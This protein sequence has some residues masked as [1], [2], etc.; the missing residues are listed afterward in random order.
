MRPYY[1]YHTIDGQ[2]LEERQSHWAP[3]EELVKKDGAEMALTFYHGGRRA[4]LK[5]NAPDRS[6]SPPKK[7]RAPVQQRHQLASLS[8]AEE[9]AIARKA[10][11]QLIPSRPPAA[12]EVSARD[13]LCDADIDSFVFEDGKTCSAVKE[14]ERHRLLE[15]HV[16][17]ARLARRHARQ[18]GAK[19]KAAGGGVTREGDT[20]QEAET[21]RILELLKSG[22]SGV[23]AKAPGCGGDTEM[24]CVVLVNGDTDMSCLASVAAP[25]HNG[26]SHQATGVSASSADCAPM[27]VDPMEDNMGAG[28]VSMAAP[29]VAPAAERG[30]SEQA[31][32]GSKPQEADAHQHRSEDCNTHK[33]KPGSM[34]VVRIGD[35]TSGILVAIHPCGRV[36]DFCVLPRPEST[37][38]VAWMLAK[39]RR[40]LLDMGI[41]EPMTIIY[42]DAC[43]LSDHFCIEAAKPGATEEVRALAKDRFVIDRVHQ[44]GHTRPRCWGVHNM[45]NYPDLKDINSEVCEQFFPWWNGFASQ[46]RY[47]NVHYFKF[48]YQVL[49]QRNWMK[50]H[51]MLP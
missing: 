23:S 13:I 10:E 11:R 44:S 28:Q 3:V 12:P 49:R 1:R 43:H 7:R 25:Q 2:G 45:A 22:D 46:L 40:R 37:T 26:G 34:S 27:N 4:G 42:D 33:D 39:F 50:D 47:T 38:Q 20:D 18:K 36:A 32:R 9:L 14:Q 21:D 24:S 16:G 31:A 5:R 19:S 30:Q 51:G 15:R 17:R 48:A 35:K 6:C 29:V 8:S 41:V